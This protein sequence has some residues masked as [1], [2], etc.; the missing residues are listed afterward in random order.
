V[1][2][3]TYVGVDPLELCGSEG[4]KCGLS[5]I[6]PT[7]ALWHDYRAL[8]FDGLSGTLFRLALRKDDQDED[9]FGPV[10]SEQDGRKL[11]ENWTQQLAGGDIMLFLSFVNVVELFVWEAGCD[12][13]T[14]VSRV[15]KTLAGLDGDNA[16]TPTAF[17]R[18]PCAI[19]EEATQSYAKLENYL[20]SLDEEQLNGLSAPNYSE[21]VVK[22]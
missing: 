15:V 9:A 18:L 13:P 11:M 20:M 22:V 17:S 21:V 4:W 6:P 19:P 14:C 8:N 7:E 1:S 10:I 16:P 5:E 3:G 2:N 12:S